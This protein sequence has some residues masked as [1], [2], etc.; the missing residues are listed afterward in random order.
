MA[1]KREGG[2]DAA[3]SEQDLIARYFAPLAHD[4][5]GAYGLMDDAAVIEPPPGA[6]LVVTTDALVA[7]VHFFSDDAPADIAWKALAVNVSDLAAKGAAPLAYSLALALP[8]PPSMEFLAGFS[9]GLAEA[10][11]HFGIVLS[12]G[13]TTAT[14][15]GAL[16]VSITA[17]GTVP[18]GQAV[19]RGGARPGDS[20]YVSGTIGDAALGLKLRRGDADAAAWPISD[21]A[22]EWLIRRYLRPEPRTALAGALLAHATAAMDISDG[23][24]IDCGRLCAASGVAARVAASAIPLS[25]AA[26]AVT[27]AESLMLHT[28]LTGG[29]DYEV[30]FAVRGGEEAALESAAGHAGIPVARI[31]AISEGQAALTLLDNDGAPLDL[32]AGGFDHFTAR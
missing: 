11:R 30:L 23:F 24:V 29:D 6:D 7:G 20:L 26:S 27:A 5:P 12:G 31:G 18:R 1:E 3:L 19:R 4:F 9:A 14:R 21:A 8:P 22:R 25:Q 17:L 32:G 2:L 15:G 13:D 16:M 28:A 10:Q